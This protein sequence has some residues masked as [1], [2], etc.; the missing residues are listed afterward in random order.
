MKVYLVTTGGYSDYSVQMVCSTRERAEAASRFFYD[1][2]GVEEWE[3]DKPLPP[4]PMWNVLIYP[5]GEKADAASLASPT[6]VPCEP[7]FGPARHHYVNKKVAITW[8]AFY[9]VVVMAATKE[10]ALKI[11]R[12]KVAVARAHQ[13]GLS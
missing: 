2:N 9:S 8:P 5:G 13:E 11:A 12:D 6:I 1:V 4:E 3:L 10:L 7:R